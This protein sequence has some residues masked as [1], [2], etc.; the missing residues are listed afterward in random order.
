MTNQTSNPPD[1]QLISQLPLAE[2]KVDVKAIESEL[3]T[4]VPEDI[5][6]GIEPLTGGSLLSCQAGGV[7]WAS[8]TVVRVSES[9]DIEALS[10]RIQ[11]SWGRANEFDFEIRGTPEDL[12]RIILSGEWSQNYF[13]GMQM[14]D[15]RIASFGPCFELVPE[16]DGHAWDIS[17][18]E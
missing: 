13:I 8:H 11:E 7:S 6:Q 15:L 2:I 10:A 14:G 4:F 3:A 18:E 9:P 17:A 12:H 5:V 16:R 1:R